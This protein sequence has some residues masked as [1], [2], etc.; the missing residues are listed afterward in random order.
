MSGNGDHSIADKTAY[1][2]KAFVKKIS[3]LSS[4]A[5]KKELRFKKVNP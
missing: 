1:L 3:P 4:P 2:E 5:K